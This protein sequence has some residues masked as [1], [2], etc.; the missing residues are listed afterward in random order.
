MLEEYPSSIQKAMRSFGNSVAVCY[1][2]DIKLRA[3]LRA[4]DIGLKRLNLGAGAGLSGDGT[5]GLS[6]FKKGWSTDVRL[7]YF[8]GRILQPGLYSELC[9]QNIAPETTKYFPAYRNGEF[10]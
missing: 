8:C 4:S 3:R 5:D 7:A 1:K 2:N 9:R 6:R 10:G